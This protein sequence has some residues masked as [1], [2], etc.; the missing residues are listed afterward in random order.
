MLSNNMKKLAG[1]IYLTLLVSVLVMFSCG[2]DFPER[3]ESPAANP[4]SNI[5]YFPEQINGDY[6][7]G[8]DA[9]SIEIPIAREVTAGALTLS[10][11]ITGNEAF[12]IPASVSFAAGESETSFTLSIGQIDLMK[13][14]LLTIEFDK[15]QTENPYA[16]SDK[17]SILSLNV[18]KEDFAPYAMGVYYSEWWGEEW[19]AEL[20]YS[21]ATEQYRIKAFCGYDGYDAFFK[22]DGGTEITMVGGSRLGSRTAFPTGDE[23]PPYGMVYASYDEPEGPFEY[24]PE[25]KT[26]IFGYAWRVSAGTFGVG[27]DTYT[28]TQVY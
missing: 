13:R 25:T 18:L 22:W 11:K 17:I 14:Y 20:E 23:Y 19:D 12:S 5:V 15:D 21:P 8:I 10:L 16:I 26:F 3:E 1:S 28:I 2:E 24:D 9:T 6:V 27:P 4:N 7:I